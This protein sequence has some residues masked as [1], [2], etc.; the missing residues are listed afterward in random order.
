MI[1]NPRWSILNQ[2]TYASFRG[3][4]RQLNTIRFATHKGYIKTVLTDSLSADHIT[5]DKSDQ[6]RIRPQ[7]ELAAGRHTS[8]PCHIEGHCSTVPITL[9]QSS[10]FYSCQFDRKN[11]ACVDQDRLMSWDCP[12]R[13]TATNPGPRSVLSSARRT[14][15]A[16]HV[17]HIPKSGGSLLMVGT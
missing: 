3:G 4:Q 7:S 9:F 12:V 11:P 16:Q 2:C 5:R 10:K 13:L 15:P 8:K 17:T 6:I 1:T 14:V